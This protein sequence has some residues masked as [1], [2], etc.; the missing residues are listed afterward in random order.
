MLVSTRP[1]P[2][3]RTLAP[4]LALAGVAALTLAA[5]SAGAQHLAARPA[6]PRPDSA[7]RAH[8]VR[9]GETLWA[10]AEQYLGDSFRWPV[11]REANTDRVSDPHWIYPGQKLRIPAAAPAAAES[12]A[13]DS[14]VA[15]AAAPAPAATESFA[16]APSPAA[17]V[18]PA[19]AAPAAAPA[20][21]AD[22]APARPYEALAAP[23]VGPRN[24]LRGAGVIVDGADIPSAGSR[25]VAR[26]L[27]L[28]DRIVLSLPAGARTERGTTYLVATPGPKVGN[29]E[30][31]VPRGVAIL[32]GGGNESLRTAR[33]VKLFGLVEAGLPVIPLAADA[34]AAG[35]STPRVT[36]VVWIP[37]AAELPTL[38]AYVL[39]GRGARDG[40]RVGDRFELVADG[41]RTPDGV[42]LPVVRAG[43]VRVVRVTD[44]ASTAVVVHH[45]QP[46]IAPG[47]EARP[48]PR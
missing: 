11:I 25:G 3:G 21:R 7:A 10:L 5:P 16:L 13:A 44:D 40:V 15:P 46:A 43:V 2:A 35:E 47:V 36:H 30:V 41:R 28:L 18:R 6:Q 29:G 23:Y 4:L 12:T 37:G 45:D 20:A 39:L 32:D 24:A 38:Q 22:S 1:A 34:V 48:L 14:A 31:V 42:P 27:Q 8:E 26:R 9:R 17:P 33:L 19:T